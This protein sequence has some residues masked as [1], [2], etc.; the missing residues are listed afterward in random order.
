MT[1]K[2]AYTKSDLV[3]IILISGNNLDVFGPQMVKYRLLDL[4]Q[5]E[6]VMQHATV[7]I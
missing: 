1:F 4:L 2:Y 5:V 6:E 3:F 7:Y